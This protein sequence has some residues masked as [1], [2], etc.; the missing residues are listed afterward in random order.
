MY[1]LL[2]EMRELSR[3]FTI[4]ELGILYSSSNKAILK[5]NM[6][7]NINILK[8]NARAVLTNHYQRDRV[9]YKAHLSKIYDMNKSQKILSDYNHFDEMLRTGV[10]N[11]SFFA[12]MG[13]M[14]L[15]DKELFVEVVMGLITVEQYLNNPKFHNQ[16]AI[17]RNIRKAFSSKN[18]KKT[19]RS[20]K[21]Q[22]LNNL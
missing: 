13:S 4:D 16:E 9:K 19:M 12:P 20:I 21:L 14:Y 15:N 6:P 11:H 17:G 22:I 7:T 8:H 2:E 1:K 5:H 18:V 10:Y 3:E